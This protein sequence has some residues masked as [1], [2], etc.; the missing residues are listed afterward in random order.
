MSDLKTLIKELKDATTLVNTDLSGTDFKTR[1]GREMAKNQAA[2]KINDLREE[3]KESLMKTVFTLFPIGKGSSKFSDLAK[4]EGGALVVDG[5]E[6]YTNLATRVQQT[7]GPS[8]TFG[9]TQFIV[10]STALRNWGVENEV[11]VMA[12]NFSV[13]TITPTLRDVINT[14]RNLVEKT[15]GQS[16]VKTYVEGQV[17]TQALEQEVD[18][19]VVPVVILNTTQDEQPSLIGSLFRGRGLTIDT[20][21]HEVT[22]EFVTKTFKQIQKQLKGS[23]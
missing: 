5:E 9:L 13:D 8:K 18:S 14:V 19:K 16:L 10:L 1:P 4:L 17:V 23:N 2:L 6:F 22:E 21:T 3:Y 12:L 11:D 15:N 20:E 7:M